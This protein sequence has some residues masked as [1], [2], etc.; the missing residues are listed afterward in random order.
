[1][2]IQIGLGYGLGE[3]PPEC[4]RM[5]QVQAS[6][7]QVHDLWRCSRSVT[8]GVAVKD[9]IDTAPGMNRFGKCRLTQCNVPRREKFLVRKR[10]SCL[11]LRMPR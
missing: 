11:L 2:L 6:C 3:V 8:F 10:R 7:Q 9:H 1:M 4:R 5:L